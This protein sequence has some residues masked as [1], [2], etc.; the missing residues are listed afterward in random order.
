MGEV[1]LISD[2]L[3]KFLRVSNFQLSI[4]LRVHLLGRIKSTAVITGLPSPNTVFILP[5]RMNLAFSTATG[6]THYSLL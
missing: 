3:F 5:C 6:R 1:R 4:V 2:D